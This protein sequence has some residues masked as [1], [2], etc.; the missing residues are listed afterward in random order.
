M[1]VLNIKKIVL[2]FGIVAATS[3]AAAYAVPTDLQSLNFNYKVSG[4][5]NPSWK[6]IEVFTSGD[7]TYIKY[8]NVHNMQNLPDLYLKSDQHGIPQWK[9]ESPYVVVN[10]PISSAQI[11]DP[12]S[13]K[14]IY[15]LN[16]K[17]SAMPYIAP[18]PKLTA[19]QLAGVF[20]EFDL[21]VGGVDNQKFKNPVFS[22]SI[23]YDADLTEHW[24]FGVGFGASYNG[25]SNEIGTSA[26]SYKIKSYDVELMTRATY[27]FFNGITVFGKAGLAYVINKSTDEVGS[28]TPE[29]DE[30]KVVPKLAIGIGYQTRSGVGFNLQLSRLFD[31]N[32]TVNA[33][34]LTVGIGYY[35]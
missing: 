23:G 19:K 1:D 35:F 26:S 4:E 34:A 8:A 21:G 24:L 13:G 2:A 16:L 7:K 17:N 12:R 5:G 18:A 20:V 28:A 9:W 22:G 32:K 29:P 15:T 11:V 33:N 3:F 10:M 30:K 25:K 6:P 27:L 31:S 14:V